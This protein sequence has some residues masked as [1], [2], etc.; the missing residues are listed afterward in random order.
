MVKLT[1]PAARSKSVTVKPPK[2]RYQK[3]TCVVCRAELR[4]DHALGDLCCD[5]HPHD[6]YNPRHDPHLDE[7]ILTLL[8]R[9]QGRPVN[10]YRAL[11]CDSM[12][13]N[14]DAVRDAVDKLNRSGVVGVRGHFGVGYEIVATTQG[15]RRRKV[16]A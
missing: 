10:L 15:G 5:S 4:G 6:G 7:R 3:S 13:S 2:P 1:P 8:Y 9:A 11:G 16:K 12:Q 14:R